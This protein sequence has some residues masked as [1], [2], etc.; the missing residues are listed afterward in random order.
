MLF[1]FKHFK[2]IYY[3]LIT[4]G[5]IFLAGT[6]GFKIIENYSTLDAFYMTVITVSTVGFREVE[7]LSDGG[8]IFTAI[9]IL[10]SFGTFAYAITSV[11]RYI[12]SGEY[13][14]YFKDYKVNAEISELHDHVIVC[15]YGRNGQQAVKT[16]NAHKQKFII[17]ESR[18]HIM[19]ELRSDSKF[20]Y[21]H[22]NAT[23]EDVLLKAGVM[24]AKALITT[25]PQD[26]DNVFVVLT[27]RELNDK[28]VI[29]SRASEDS[30][31]R[32]LRI[33]G[34]DNVIMPDKVGGSHMASLVVTPDVMEFL[35]K[36]STIGAGNIN[37][38]EIQF[39]NIPEKLRSKSFKDINDEFGI[40]AK[41][42]GIKTDS[43]EYI[44]NPS[45]DLQI[46]PNSKLFV[47]GTPEQLKKLNAILIGL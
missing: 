30:S 19:E 27:V 28:I 40:G 36:I 26:A 7:T 21:V 3:A 10:T 25:L 46:A 41:I 47:L 37:L 2:E 31:E 33:A 38:E 42:I 23:S 24:R 32:K 5:L 11:T 4:M 14:N 15:G 34:A 20:L 13:R 9:L 39:E 44:V 8:K 18:D 16:L 1:S 12:I 29:I 45:S 6:I 22:G 43:G 35:D 17:I